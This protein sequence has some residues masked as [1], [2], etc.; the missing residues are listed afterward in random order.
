MAYTEKNYKTAKQVKEAFAAG[1]RVSVY[2][3]G[4]F[5]GG[6]LNGTVYLEGPHSPAPHSWYLQATA[7]NGV[8]TAIK[9]I[10][11]Q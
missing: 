11:R 9:R 6:V 4:P 7:E 10:K 8:I 2:Q 1:T 3:P 5:G